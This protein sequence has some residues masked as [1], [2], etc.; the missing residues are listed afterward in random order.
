MCQEVQEDLYL[1]E[2]AKSHTWFWFLPW[3]LFYLFLFVV[4]LL[5]FKQLQQQIKYVMHWKRGFI[6]RWKMVYFRKGLRA[7]GCYQLPQ[8]S[9]KYTLYA[10]FFPPGFHALLM[11]I[12]T[13]RRNLNDCSRIEGCRNLLI[14][15]LWHNTDFNVSW[16]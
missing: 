2:R 3:F 8:F 13:I 11:Q 6:K 14:R 12:T 15:I 1:S 7:L 4:S 5:S 16:V 10:L 9:L